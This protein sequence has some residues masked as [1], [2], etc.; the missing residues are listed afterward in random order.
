MSRVQSIERAFA[1]LGA[2]DR[3]S[4]RRDRG[5]RSGRAAEEH[6]GAAPRLA[7]AR[8]GARRAGP[9][10]ARA[11][12]SAADRHPGRRRPTDRSLGRSPDRSRRAGGDHRRGGRS[13]DPGRLPR[14]LR[15]PGRHAESRRGPRLDRDAV[16]A[17]CGVVGS[18]PP[19]HL[20]AGRGRAP[21]LARPLERFTAGRLSSSPTAIRERVRESSSTAT[22]GPT[23]SSTK[24]STP[25]RPRSPTGRRGGRR[26][27]P[28]RAVVPLPGARR[29]ARGGR[30]GRR[31]GRPDL[32][33]P[34][35]GRRG[36]DRP[37]TPVDRPLAP[38]R[39]LVS[40]R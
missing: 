15:R 26:G 27:P 12:G 17:P 13:V 25:S 30:V 1:V 11:I 24:G 31:F 29:G 19:R 18:G 40:R 5:G 9:G 6:G 14:P 20:H 10:R 16:P 33:Q 7:R 22:R 34:A 2:L 3:R 39:R 35:P 36:P 32:G 4:A 21:Y 38:A 37:L 28:P 23:T 8:E